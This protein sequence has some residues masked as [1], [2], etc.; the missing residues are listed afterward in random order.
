MEADINWEDTLENIKIRQSPITLCRHLKKWI[1]DKYGSDGIIGGDYMTDVESEIVFY[2]ESWVRNTR[3]ELF[4]LKPT[5]INSYP[6]KVTPLQSQTKILGD[7][8]EDYDM[9]YT[10]LRNQL[11]SDVW[12]L[13]EQWIDYNFR[14]DQ[15]APINQLIWVVT[16]CG[17]R[18]LAIYEDISEYMD[19]HL[20][21]SGYAFVPVCIK[22]GLVHELDESL[23]EP[24]SFVAWKE[25]PVELGLGYIE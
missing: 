14:I 21:Y 4:R 20:L 3:Q 17:Y 5:G 7:T 10:K 19:G 9:A 11:S 12:L 8:Y 2:V 18:G 13:R 16:E 23:I 24:D 6:V 25:P 15:D 1:D 22:R